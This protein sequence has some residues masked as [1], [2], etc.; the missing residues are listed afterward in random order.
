MSRNPTFTELEKI[1]YVEK[2]SH[3]IIPV[4]WWNW[5]SR[6]VSVELDVV[7]TDLSLTT[8]KAGHVLDEN[9]MMRVDRE[10][11]FRTLG[12][13]EQFIYTLENAHK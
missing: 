3:K 4:L 2:P 10:F 8:A 13:A 5:S 11:L 6:C 12:E 1:Y 9:K 7:T